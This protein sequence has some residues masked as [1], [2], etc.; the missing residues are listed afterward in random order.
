MTTTEPVVTYEKRGQVAYITLNRPRALNAI[1]SELQQRLS[2]V[3]IEFRDEDEMLVAIVTGEGGRAFSAGAD[4]KEINQSQTIGPARSLPYTPLRA[5][6]LWKPVIAAIDGYCLGGGLEL[7]LQCDIRIATQKSVFG[8]PEPRNSGGLAGFGLF[9]LSRTIPMGEAMYMHLT[10]AHIDADRA[11]RNGL[12]QSVSPDRD[13]LLQEADRIA[14]EIQLCSPLAIRS[15]KQVI[16][17]TRD[18]PLEYAVKLAEPVL[19]AILKTEDRKEA[20]RAFVEKRKPQ[21]KMR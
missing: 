17:Q 11:F 15:I 21:W 9:Y 16:S 12:I 7:A 1:N 14:D 6:N 4:L 5:V 8:L 10:G 3:L 20:S 18:L 13:A 2:D 19:E